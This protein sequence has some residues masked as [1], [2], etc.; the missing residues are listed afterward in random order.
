[1]EARTPGSLGTGGAEAQTPE[2][3]QGEPL[4]SDDCLLQKVE[5]K[6]LP[7]GYRGNG[8]PG[9]DFWL[10]QAGIGSLSTER[11]GCVAGI[12]PEEK[13]LGT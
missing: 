11:G 3:H 13:G 6:G 12:H 7:L 2:P 4:G 1:M 8:V 10:K 9:P 5:S